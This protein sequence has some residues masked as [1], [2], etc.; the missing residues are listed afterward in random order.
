[1]LIMGDA[2]RLQ[3]IVWNLLSNAIKFTPEG[4]RVEVRLARAGDEAEISVADTGQ[5][6]EPEFLP[7]IFERFRQADASTTRAHGGLGL[8]LS[9]VR[10]LVELHGGSVRVESAGAGRGATFSVRLPLAE[11]R[12]AQQ[13]ARADA[14]AADPS[15]VRDPRSQIL[16]GLRVLV[17]ED[18]AD[19][20]YMLGKTLERYGAH[21]T[22]CETAD[23]AL[24]AYGGGEFDLLISDIGMPEADGYWLVRRLRALEA[25]RGVR[26]LPAVAL[27]AYARNEDRDAAL[28]A[29]FEAHIAKPVAPAELVE[30]AAR[31]TGRA[32]TN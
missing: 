27:T 2:D 1:M 31:L 3:Q 28:A 10:H 29:G 15:A 16:A 19:T 12:V 18:D 26:R 5:G 13:E 22:G 30:A 7:H 17:V 20:L 25:E 23:A 11:A 21:T 4:G 6:I 32:T 14:P 9:I 24:E 8:G